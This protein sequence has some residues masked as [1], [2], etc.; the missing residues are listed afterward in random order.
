[1]KAL[2]PFTH[3][4]TAISSKSGGRT[5]RTA[6]TRHRAPNKPLLLLTVIDLLLTLHERPL[7]A[8]VDG[9]LWPDRDALRWHR[10]QCLRP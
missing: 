4:H 6:A 3:L 10:E 5:H 7:V 9:A 1:M 8:P 2:H